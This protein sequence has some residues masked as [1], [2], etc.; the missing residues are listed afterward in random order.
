MRSAKFLLLAVA[1]L[2]PLS[3]GAAQDRDW[4]NG[5]D[6]DRDYRGSNGRLDEIATELSDRADQ[7]WTAVRNR[8]PRNEDRN[9]LYVALRN[10][11]RNARNYSARVNPSDRDTYRV[12]AQ[13]LI[14]EAENINRLVDRF[15]NMYRLQDQWDGV[16]LQVSRLGRF[17]GIPYSGSRNLARSDPYY[18][19]D[20]RSGSYG[21]YRGGDGY[22]SQSGV[23]RWRGR[24]DGSDYI[25]LRGNRVDIRHLQAAPITNTNYDLS[26]PLPRT[27]VNVQ[28]RRLRGRG[29]VQVI[30]Q[31]S[32]QNA[33]T[34]G[35]LI[36]DSDPGAD[37]YEFELAW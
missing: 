7:L 37:D 4:R 31:P 26:S 28:L 3:V 11:A 27:P 20:R 33:Y 30:Q 5:R 15:Q 8:N 34:A 23:L 1:L 32:P 35:V 29:R 12:G 25:Y 21:D 22:G 17:Y 9:D 16:E 19:D 6:R 13:Q 14:R 18:R 10:F 24:V 2:A 36:E